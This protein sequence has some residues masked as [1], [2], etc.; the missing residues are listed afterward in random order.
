MTTVARKKNELE[1]LKKSGRI[2]KEVLGK[3]EKATKIG[4]NTLQLDELAEAEITKHGATASFLGFKKYPFHI[5]VSVND[6]VVHGLPNQY[7]LQKGDIC[8][9]DL[10][11]NYNGW[12]TDGA[13]TVNLGNTNPR[14]KEMIEATK[15][16]L[17]EAIKIIR[18]GI[19]TGD[20]GWV[21]EKTIRQRKLA[22]IE[23]LT[24]HGVGKSIHE[25]PAI[26]NFGQPNSGL[27]IKEGM[28]LAIEPMVA[29]TSGKI[30]IAEDGWSVKTQDA[31]L[32]CHF[33]H[34]VL[35]TKT[36]CQVLT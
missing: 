15:K 12:H 36:G 14:V 27:K 28:V 35:V 17:D 7:R 1:N 22:V 18:P 30:K 19:K 23:D 20:I 31:S 34:T 33:E 8:G 21:I 24:G 16:A 25:E 13:I 2:L 11:I 32:T 9:L 5:C 3:L 4:V 26:F 10:G 29:M 6:T